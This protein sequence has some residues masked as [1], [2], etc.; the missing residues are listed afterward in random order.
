MIRHDGYYIEEPTEVHDG[1]SKGE[2][3][4]YSFT[5]YYFLDKEN[6]KT[7]SKHELISQISDFTKKDFNGNSHSNRKFEIN[8]KN[9]IIKKEY[10]FAKDIN[11]NIIS[12]NHFLINN[13]KNLYFIPWEEID[14]KKS[15][16]FKNSCINKIFGPFYHKKFDIYF[17]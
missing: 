9:I 6:L 16:E 8:G 17:E 10:S 13:K 3:S 4:S 5:A 7:N 1:R 14:K 11:I 15:N 2:K 12:T